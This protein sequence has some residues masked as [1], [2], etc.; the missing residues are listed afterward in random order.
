MPEG[1]SLTN[2]FLIKSCEIQKLI[3][4]VL[5]VFYKFETR[6]EFWH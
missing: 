3:E 5:F 1:L 6:I 4:M 2:Q